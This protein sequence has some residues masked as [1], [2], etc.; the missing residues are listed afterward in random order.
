[1]GARLELTSWKAANNSTLYG[2]EL[3]AGT[4]EFLDTPRKDRDPK[5]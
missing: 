4:V 1:M 5:G 3:T 2:M